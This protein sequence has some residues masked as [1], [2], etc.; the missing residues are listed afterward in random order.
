[1]K[2]DSYDGLKIDHDG[3][4]S[5]SQDTNYVEMVFFPSFPLAGFKKM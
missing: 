3:D 1:M 5:K 4:A 2:A